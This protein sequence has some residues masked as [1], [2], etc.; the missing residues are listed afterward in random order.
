LLAG[1]G[2]GDGKILAGLGLRVDDAARN[3][4]LVEQVAQQLAGEAA[5]REDRLDV[6]AEP[7]HHPRDVDAAAAGIAARSR[8]AQ[9]AARHHPLHRGRQIDRGI[10]SQG[11][12]LDHAVVL[13]CDGREGCRTAG[14]G[15]QSGA[16]MCRRR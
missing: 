1:G 9:L 11:H 2:L 13:R 8:A 7:L 3:A 5:G 4:F 12:D 14:R 6:A 10:G 16:A 15:L